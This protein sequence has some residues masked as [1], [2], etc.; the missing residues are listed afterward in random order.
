L[1]QPS[2]EPLLLTGRRSPPLSGHCFQHPETERS[3]LVRRPLVLAAAAFAAATL[4]A[5]CG[6]GGGTTAAGTGNHAMG[7]GADSSIA[8][9]AR[10]VTVAASSFRFEPAE[11]HARVGENLAVVLTS[12]DLLHD[13][14]IDELDAHVAADRG[15]TARGGVVASRAGRYPYYCTVP[16][17][18]QAGMEGVLIVE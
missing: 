4:L 14:T 13:F 10:E 1:G 9:G 12:T 7:H 5:A 6:G 16:G 2:A 15:E 8:E 17:H 3:A 18:R 11:I